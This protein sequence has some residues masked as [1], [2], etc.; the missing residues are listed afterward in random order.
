M[1]T[2]YNPFK[3]WGSWVGALIGIIYP[4][5]I[6]SLVTFREYLDMI[7]LD[8]LMSLNGVDGRLVIYGSAIT[9]FLI[10]YGIHSLIKSLSRRHK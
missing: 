6:F 2:S 10:G 9:G 8:N 7:F 3:M 5:A 1:K 4:F